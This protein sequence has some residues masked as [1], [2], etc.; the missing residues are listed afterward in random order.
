MYETIHRCAFDDEIIC[1]SLAGLMSRRFVVVNGQGDDTTA[2]EVRFDLAGCLVPVHHRH[3]QVHQDHFRMEILGLLDG[4]APVSG[5]ADHLD[6]GPGIPQRQGQHGRQPLAD[7]R[8]IIHDQNPNAFHG[9][10]IA[11]KAPDHIGPWV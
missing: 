11:D 10:R 4:L 6:S 5:L 3:F 9:D 8:Q 7:M 2:G 1:A